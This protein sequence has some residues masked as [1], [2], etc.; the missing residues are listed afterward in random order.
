MIDFESIHRAADVIRQGGVVAYPTESCFGLG[1]DPDN[2][3]AIRRILRMKKRPAN[4]GLILISDRLSRLGK[5][6]GEL[7]L[8]HRQEM[9]TS[10]PGPFT[11]LVPTTGAVS[12][13]LKGQHTLVAVRVTAHKEAALLCRLA[14]KPIVSTSANRSG[15]KSI[16]AYNRISQ[17][18]GNEVD[19]VVNGQ[20]GRSSRP[21]TI[22]NSVTGEILRG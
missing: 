19:Y 10:W 7:P 20:I 22:R 4:K 14:G 11:W 12:F 8:S 17:V 18:F 1:C 15:Q 3:D 5:Y 6:T 13:W 21:S 9:M 16:K 2:T